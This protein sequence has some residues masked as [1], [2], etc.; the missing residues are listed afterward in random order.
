MGVLA[1][2][3]LIA[4]SQRT[5][6]ADSEVVVED[7]GLISGLDDERLGRRPLGEGGLA[8]GGDCGHS[9][10]PGLLLLIRRV[11]PRRKR[12]GVGAAVSFVS[13][14]CKTLEVRTGHASMMPDR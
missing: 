11:F 9:D 3:A 7:A 6:A 12:P 1:R 10:L 8:G 5:L 4:E 13:G 14:S 2:G